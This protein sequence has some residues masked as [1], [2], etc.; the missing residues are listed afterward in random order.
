MLFL[1]TNLTE[2]PEFVATFGPISNK[3]GKE[4]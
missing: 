1:L 3:L 2:I 4:I